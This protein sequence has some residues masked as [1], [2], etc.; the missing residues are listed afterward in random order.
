MEFCTDIDSLS[1]SPHPVAEGV[2][3]KPLVTKK[4]HGLDVTCVLVKV[5]VGIEV[6]E[7]IHETQADILY[8]LQGRGEMFVEGAG[9]LA[10]EPGVVVRVPMGVRHRIFNVTEELLLYDV[11]QPATI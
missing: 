3:I 6:A 10:I 5:P 8:P 2:E 1:W 4:D 11:F 9:N 7:H